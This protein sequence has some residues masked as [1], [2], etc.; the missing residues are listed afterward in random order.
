MMCVC[1]D[2]ISTFLF[3]LLILFLKNLSWEAESLS[4]DFSVPFLCLKSFKLQPVDC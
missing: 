2:C 1:H 3:C 4:V